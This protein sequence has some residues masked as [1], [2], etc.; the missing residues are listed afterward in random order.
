MLQALQ[1]KLFQYLESG[2]GWSGPREED[3]GGRDED[4]CLN[5]WGGTG[6]VGSKRSRVG[7]TGKAFGFVLSIPPWLAWDSTPED[8]HSV[9]DCPQIGRDHCP[10]QERLGGF[11]RL[12]VRPAAFKTS[13][14]QDYEVGTVAFPSPGFPCCASS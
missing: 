9:P 14:R 5:S 7:S 6:G 13:D 8:A 12:V 2:G 10:S 3:L 11:I 4:T 1:I